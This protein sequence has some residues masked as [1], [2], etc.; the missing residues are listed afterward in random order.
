MSLALVQQLNYESK[1]PVDGN[2]QQE[3][4][5]SVPA[6]GSGDYY[7]S[8]YCVINIPCASNSHVFDPM[9]LFSCFKATVM[10]ADQGVTPDHSADNF[11]QK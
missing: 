10:D 8:S 3:I 1:M 2:C 9:N 4:S 11:I 7:A 5:I 6:T